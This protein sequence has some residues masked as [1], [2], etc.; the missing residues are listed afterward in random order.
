MIKMCNSSSCSAEKLTVKNK[1]AL[2]MEFNILTKLFSLFS[3]AAQ[4]CIVK[5]GTLKNTGK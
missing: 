2:H 5:P 4:N 3:I 1:N